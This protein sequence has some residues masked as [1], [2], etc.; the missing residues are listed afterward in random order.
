MLRE[1]CH[2]AGNSKNVKEEIYYVSYGDSYDLPIESLELEEELEGENKDCEDS[3]SREC[4][5]LEGDNEE[6]EKK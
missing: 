6:V 4:G 3:N 1:V 5:V 2:S